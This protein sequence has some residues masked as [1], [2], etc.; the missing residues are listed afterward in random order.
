MSNENQKSSGA[1]TLV[2]V[3]GGALFM[4]VGMWFS[5]NYHIGFID[6]L[7][8]QGLPIDLGETVATIGVLLILFPAIKTF[9]INPLEEAING[10][11]HQLEK[12]F[13]EV[14]E[15]R[16]QMTKMKSDYESRLTASEANAREQ[17]Q[18][19]IKEA[20]TL[21]ATLEANA[22]AEAERYLEQA[23]QTIDQEK[24]SAI[25]ELRSTVIDLTLGATEK[26]IGANMDEARNRSLIESFM[27]T[28]VSR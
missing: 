9:F 12:T 15:L 28:E 8:K 21:R 7:A 26:L 22:Q 6:D 17:I 25:Q 11:N 23:R 3:I 14:E 20:Q 13:S 19:Q 10:R 24:Q 27:T 5:K 18:Q 4:V 16:D 1:P 2:L